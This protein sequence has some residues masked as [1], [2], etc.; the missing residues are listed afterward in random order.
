MLVIGAHPDDEDTDLITLLT[1]GDGAD[2]AY[3]SLNRGEGGQNLVG[4]ELGDALGVLRT[5]ELLAAR[6]LDGARQFFTRAYD[7]GYSRSLDDTWAQWPR[8]TLL[9]DVVR[10]VRAFQPQVIVSIFSGTPRDGHGQHQAAGWLAHEAFRLAGDPRAFPEQIREG[11][12]PWL[13]QRLFRSSRFD[14][15]GT[16]LILDAGRLDPATGQ[17]FHQTAMASRS[18]HRSQDMGQLQQVGASPVRLALVEDRTGKGA[19][20]IFA[21]I[22][23]ALA[24]AAGPAARSA[25]DEYARRVSALRG[26]APTLAQVR[27]ASAALLRAEKQV[28][29]S[30]ELASERRWLDQAGQAVAGV[31][32]D[33]YADDSLLV[34]G[35][36]ATVT[37]EA[38]NASRDRLVLRLA[39]AGVADT[40]LEVALAPGERAVL[41]VRLAVP[42]SAP[43]TAVPQYRASHDVAVYEREGWLGTPADAEPVSALVARYTLLGDGPIGPIERPVVFRWNE[44][45]KGEERSPVV[46]V[47]RVD[48]SMSP[49]E[50]PWR[51]GDRTARTLRVRLRH[52]VRDSTRGVVR[53]EVPSGWP[54][55]P[56]QRFVLGGAG[57]TRELT[58]AVRPPATLSGE[59]RTVRAVVQDDAGAT[60]TVG[61]QL[62]DYPHIRP[63]SS[64]HPAETRVTP[65]DL[66]LP[67]RRRIGYVRGAADA[68]PEALAAA[69]FPIEVLAPGAIGSTDL[70]R[71]DAIVIGPRAYETDAALAGAT[72]RLLAWVRAGGLMLVQYQQY[73]YFLGGHAP[74]RLAVWARSF[75]NAEG[76]Q[77]MGPGVKPPYSAS[78]LGG[79][80]RVTDERAPVTMLRADDP[81]LR[82]PNR[83]GPADWEGWV[84]ERGLYFAREWGP[85]FRPVLAM[86]DPGEPPREGGLLVA[87]EGKGAYVYTGL[88]F[89]RQLPAGVPGAFRLF[90]NLLAVK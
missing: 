71:Y 11:L 38:Y 84:Q 31:L 3:L 64:F 6:R 78:L 14:T 39:L 61:R 83:I 4:P 26:G 10:V 58:F 18:L 25:L 90:A 48:V 68:V 87:R 36:T 34:P 2:A 89:F 70:A 46:V 43:L 80:D 54:A 40:T 63:R 51:T 5:E 85:A 9:G 24:A 28:P 69:G 42:P 45:S 27:A 33:A 56:P 29:G 15:A 52:A 65:L 1:R 86:N 17:T 37:L 88:S 16:T 50:V 62:V 21:G 32:V 19:G 44:Q 12:A 7:F 82:S 81:V 66:V 35:R 75:G 8:D 74:D 47:P 73:G 13:P 55:V 57:D 60:Y 20:G 41:P 53:L 23:T 72:P 77:A 30:A 59:R 49:G 79:H 22:D 76:G 67:V